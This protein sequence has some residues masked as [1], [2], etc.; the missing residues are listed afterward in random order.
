[1]NRDILKFWKHLLAVV[2]AVALTATA[3]YTF[4]DDTK[5]STADQPD[6]VNLAAMLIQDGHYDRARRELS[7]VDP[8]GDAPFDRPTF[9]TLKGLIALK[10]SAYK[11]AIAH[12]DDAI[13]YGKSDDRIFV[14]LAQAYYRLQ[15][16]ERTI[17]SVRNAD[18]AGEKIADMYLM[19]A[20]AHRELGQNHEAWKTLDQGGQRFTDRPTFLRQ[21]VFL[22]VEMGLYQR[23]SELGEVFL[24]QTQ[25]GVDDYLAIGEAFRRAGAHER[26]KYLLE[27]AKLRFPAHPKVP[28]H[29]GHVYIAT[30]HLITAGELMQ[31]AADFDGKYILESAE[32]YRRGGAF[33]RALYMNT[34]VRDQPKKFKQRVALLLDQRRFEQL[35]ALEARLSRL[36]LLEDQKILYTLAYARFQT[37]D[38]DDTERLLKHIT[39]EDLFES[40]VEL[41]RAVQLCRQEP[42]RC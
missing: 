37:G 4:A 22:L 35:S 32:L 27:E 24:A 29:L 7:K 21:Q 12:F 38:F 30:G 41:R 11:P 39:D 20:H 34:Q 16:W 25:R 40:A 14:Y 5:A 17:L 2:L 6:Y 31:Q 18:K 23:A 13:R 28:V 9:Y 8:S 33:E 36:G 1:M 3:A 26:A 10:A 42:G 19:K 15:N